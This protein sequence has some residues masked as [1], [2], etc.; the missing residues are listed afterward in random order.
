M[1]PAMY[2][3]NTVAS[4]MALSPA[5]IR[6][7]CKDDK[8]PHRKVGNQYRISRVWVEQWINGDV[9]ISTQEIQE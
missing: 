2:P 5:T 9:E 3:P 4:I 8:I 1:K 6:N 7:Y